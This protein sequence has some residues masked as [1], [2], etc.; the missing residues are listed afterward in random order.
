MFGAKST[1]RKAGK[2]SACGS[3]SRK[4]VKKGSVLDKI[5]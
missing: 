4:A 1:K 5:V 3:S 2:E